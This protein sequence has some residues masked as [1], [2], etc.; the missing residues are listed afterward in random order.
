MQQTIH[1]FSKDT[2]R[3]W[4]YLAVIF[5]V[6]AMLVVLTPKWRPFYGPETA[7]LNKTVDTLHFLLPLAWWFT[8]AHLVQGEALVGDRQ[9]WLTRPYSW[10]SLVAAKCLFCVAF[11]ILP[12]AAGDYMILAAEGFSPTALLPG[13]LWR[14]Y[15]VAAILMLPP[16]I[17]AALTRG[18]RQ[19]VLACLLLAIA[20]FVAAQ[21]EQLHPSHSIVTALTRTTSPVTERW[22]DAWG[23]GTVYACGGLI[24]VLWQYARRATLAVRAIVIAVFTWGLLS[25][26]WPPGAIA[27]TGQKWA[28]G[29][30]EI[31]VL[32]A[33]QT[34]R[35]G[36]A[37]WAGAQDRIQI[38][39]PIELSGRSRELL[40]Y[41]LAEIHF[42]P[43]SGKSWSSPWTWTVHASQRLGSE[44]IELSL[45]P[46]VF[47]RLN[48]S[49]V[50]LDAVFGVVLYEPQASVR[51][52][53]VGEWTEV[54][55]FGTV[56]LKEDRPWSPMI[57]WRAPLRYP[58]QKFVYALRGP[59]SSVLYR[60]QWSGT[61][62]PD[63]DW[64]HISPVVSFAA[65]FE[66]RESDR[67]RDVALPKEIVGE[68]ALQRPIGLIRRDLEIPSIRLGDY[69]VR[70]LP[71]RS[72]P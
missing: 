57:W 53:P 50:K 70:E 24:L 4:P 37:G 25:S 11:L 54:P 46:A 14:Y 47:Q 43:K 12:L 65:P 62:P 66:S 60:G 9:F 41:E 61:Y 18:M 26:A 35:L 1:I 17:F 71:M 49:P 33:P 69:V 21:L 38:N 67:R 64:L 32:F 23:W 48:Q 27:Q 63:S 31:A 6:T 36:S 52:R 51:L 22:T 3:S 44:W 16:F 59:D 72:S 2:R 30:P 10:K 56:A 68:F 15:H 34:A 7:A 58:S 28:A 20:F 45:D 5:V 39:I 19:F 29:H 40:E 55:G 42:T 8:I 13:L